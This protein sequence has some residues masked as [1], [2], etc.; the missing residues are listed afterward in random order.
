[1]AAFIHFRG[2]FKLDVVSQVVLLREPMLEL[3]W[4]RPLVIVCGTQVSLSEYL[5][6]LV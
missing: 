2:F 3:V 4:P 5:I 1:M 6:C